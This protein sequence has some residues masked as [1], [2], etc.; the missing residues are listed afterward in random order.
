MTSTSSDPDAADTSQGETTTTITATTHLTLPSHPT[1]LTY[2]QMNPKSHAS[3]FLGPIGTGGIS[4]VAPFFAYFLFY[5]CNEGTGCPPTSLTDW[6]T[7]WMRVGD[8]PST[9][10]KLWEWKAAGVYLAWYAFCVAGWVVLPGE[11]VEGNLLRDGKRN[12]YKQNGAV[13][14]A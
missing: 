14:P 9:A 5:A 7:M 3:E 8:W 11:K 13:L 6:R 2:S 1:P 10:G 12:L 4:F